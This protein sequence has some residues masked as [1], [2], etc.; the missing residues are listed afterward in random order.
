MGFWDFMFGG[1]RKSSAEETYEEPQERK[2][3]GDLFV[4]GQGRVDHE[5][6]KQRTG[7]TEKKSSS[8]LSRERDVRRMNEDLHAVERR[9]RDMHIFDHDVK[10]KVG[11]LERDFG[12]IRESNSP[13]SASRMREK[14]RRDIRKSYAKTQAAHEKHLD[15]LREQGA[16]ERRL[17]EESTK[18]KRIREDMSSMYRRS[19][20][21][22]MLK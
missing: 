22:G 15:E 21:S 2:A 11:K 10:K 7:E 20:G 4:G 13:V 12:K 17:S 9:A 19:G 5:I 3:Y 1:F 6:E 18:F 16:S 14:T 8:D